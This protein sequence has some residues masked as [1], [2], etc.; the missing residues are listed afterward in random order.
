MKKSLT[1]IIAAITISGCSSA[2][3]RPKAP[4][5]PPAV[6]SSWN[7][8]IG[9]LNSLCKGCSE[10][11]EDLSEK[12]ELFFDYIRWLGKLSGTDYDLEKFDI[13]PKSTIDAIM[14]QGFIGLLMPHGI[15]WN[16]KILVREESASLDL[17]AHEFGHSTDIHLSNIK[18]ALSAR[19][20][21]RV[22]SVGEAFEHYVGL[23]LLRQG[24]TS[25]GNDFF[26]TKPA[27]ISYLEELFDKDKYLASSCIISALANDIDCIASIWQYLATND[28]DNVYRRVEIIARKMGGFEKAIS[29]GYEKIRNEIIQASVSNAL[30]SAKLR[31][32]NFYK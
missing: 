25:V 32:F 4:D 30:A 24:N 18:Y 6:S 8:Y 17:I 13:V 28:S 10:C 20:R 15:Y 19:E 11:R 29:K 22:E 16:G 3:I 7:E 9:K 21:V 1:S 2:K 27:R 23:E 26:I 31:K 5:S 14:D 12:E